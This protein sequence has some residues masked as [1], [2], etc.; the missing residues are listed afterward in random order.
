[1]SHANKVSILWVVGLLAVYLK[2]NQ[3]SWNVLTEARPSGFLLN[4]HFG[5]DGRRE[6]S[7]YN[8]SFSGS[9]SEI[10]PPWS[11]HIPQSSLKLLSQRGPFAQST[12]RA[13]E[14]FPNEPSS[15][16]CYGLDI[17]CVVTL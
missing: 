5:T 6:A 4:P 14:I 2:Q 17:V 9:L 15:Q 1:M 12:P 3:T 11:L 8:E 10:L 7:G 16:S 13:L